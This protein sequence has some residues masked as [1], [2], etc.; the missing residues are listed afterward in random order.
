MKGEAL[1]S[2]PVTACIHRLAGTE[3]T[4]SLKAAGEYYVGI[5]PEGERSRISWECISRE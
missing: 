1:Y 2:P 3:F 5:Q 4:L